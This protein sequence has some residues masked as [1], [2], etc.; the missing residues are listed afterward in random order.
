MFRYLSLPLLIAL[1]ACSSTAVAPPSPGADT[2]D[3]GWFLSGPRLQSYR[4]GIDRDVHAAGS[5]SGRLEAVEK[6]NGA[7]TMMQSISAES[8]LGK[9]L[10]FSALVQT[11]DVDGWTGLWMRVDRPDGKR[12]FDNMQQRPLR[13]TT[14]WRRVEVVLDVPQDAVAVHFG[15]LQDGKGI[16]W[17]DDA[18]LETV[19]KDVPVTA[20][21]PYPQALG[22]VDFESS[23]GDE[24]GVPNGWAVRGIAHQDFVAL[25]DRTTRHG[26]AAS[27]KL[28][29]KTDEP[30]GQA[31]LAQAIRADRHAG[32][33]VRVAGWV[34]GEKLERGGRF[35]AATFAADAGPMSPGLTHASCSLDGSFD[36]RLCEAVLDVPDSADTLDVGLVLEGKGTAWLDDVSV[37]PVGLDVPLTDVDDRP[38]ALQNGSLEKTPRYVDGWF[39]SGGARAHYQ[40]VVDASVK[41]GGKQSARLEPRVR[42]PGGYGTMMQAFRAHD[43]R[44][45]RLRMN[46][47]VKGDGIDGRGDMWLRVQ[48]VDSPGDGPGLGGGR[49]AF[50]GSF[51]WKACTIV[52]DVPPR[53]DAVEVGVGLGAHGKLWL[54]DVTIETVDTTVPVTT[55]SVE[56]RRLDDGGFETSND[57]PTEWFM[58]GGAP[59]SYAVTL[60]HEQHSEGTTSARLA[61]KVEK[62]AGYGT[63][64]TEIL[65][66]SYRGKRLRMTAQ[67][68]GRGIAARG[69]M[70]LRVQAQS[71]PGDGPGLGGGSCSLAGDFDWKPCTVVFDV[72][73][74]GMWIQMGIG[75]AGPGTI[76]L[77]DVRLEE[78][79]KSAAV[80]SIVRE[81]AAPENLGFE[82]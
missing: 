81:K 26:G 46:A 18:S 69:D 61:S 41:H 23:N 68:R 65:A 72:P 80:T 16:S 57:R 25:V 48:A 35:R 73:E 38:S 77:D 66:E 24:G 21:D 20:L 6:S 62:P 63:L 34:K 78:V 4:I 60:D 54:D 5:A 13:G 19:G 8:Y 3:S 53:G 47:F 22:N 71:S 32:T 12:V 44:G 9:R 37:T 29:N 75:L 70:W 64:M 49:C 76:W 28:Q 33:R 55:E 79:E 31:E 40:A 1:A 67:V 58:S 74:R 30:R 17:I 14:T 42:E 2:G 56:R 52:F 43:L 36:W 7:G 59:A 11:R 51:D 82:R 10:R 15:L 50:S 27:A 39:M 45:K